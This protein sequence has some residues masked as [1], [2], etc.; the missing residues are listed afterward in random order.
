MPRAIRIGLVQHFAGI[1]V[2]HNIRIGRL[3]IGPVQETVMVMVDAV[4]GFGLFTMLGLDWRAGF[5]GGI[6]LHRHREGCCQNERTRSMKNTPA[7]AS[8]KGPPCRTCLP[9]HRSA[10]HR[11]PPGTWM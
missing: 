7:S 6:A 9:P 4:L 10:T 1:V 3:V 11:L 5:G 8:R 2:D